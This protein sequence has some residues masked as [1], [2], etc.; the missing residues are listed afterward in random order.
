MK[1]TI[2]IAVLASL[3]F[4]QCTN[5]K[6]SF[7]IQNGRIGPVTSQTSIQQLDSIFTN[8]SIVPLGNRPGTQGL[9]G[10]VEV[11]SK[12]GT[13]LLRLSPDNENNPGATINTVRIYDARYKTVKGLSIKS[14]FKDLK[15][16]YEITGIQT[17]IDAVVLFLKDSD[18]FITID[19]KQL[20][21]NLRYNPSLTI[22]TSQ[23][24]DNARFKYFMLAW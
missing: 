9:Q 17:S 10:E 1:N 7:T 5:K 6:D 12:D 24:P 16:N 2:F 4:A 8:D 3:L 18:I 14:T 13:K 11:F 20:P 21:E 19:K 22:E 15:D 23:I